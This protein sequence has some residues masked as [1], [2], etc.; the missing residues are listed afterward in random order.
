MLPVNIHQLL[1]LQ[2]ADP[3]SESMNGKKI[4]L[5]FIKL[6]YIIKIVLYLYITF[7]T[8]VME[9]IIEFDEMNVNYT[10]VSENDIIEITGTLKPFKTGRCTEYS[11]EPD[12]FLNES[13][14][15]YWDENWDTIEEEIIQHFNCLVHNKI[16][17]LLNTKN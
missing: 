8:H 13:D 7:N 1:E 12:T 6:L 10:I 2:V 9:P 16:V 14:E 4:K 17:N 11:F 3:T 5:F 15:E